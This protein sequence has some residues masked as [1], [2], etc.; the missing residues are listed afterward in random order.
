MTIQ[1]LKQERQ[2]RVNK[3]ITACLVFFAFSNEQFEQNKTPL[4]EGEKYV[5][6]GAGGYMPKGEVENFTNGMK[7]IDR[8]FKEQ[9]KSIKL[10]KQ[11]IAYE[12]AN[13]EAYYT[14]SIDDTVASLGEGYT[15]EEV[16]A[17]YLAERKKQLR[18]A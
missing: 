8:W 12:L 11:N 9:T 18:R 3:L 4:K 13:H 6:I 2:D 15:R 16:M 17:V 5:S 1:H 10:R 7:D 14:G